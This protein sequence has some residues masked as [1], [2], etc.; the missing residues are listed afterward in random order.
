ME[1]YGTY[2]GIVESSSDP[3]KLGRCKV[4]VP[5]FHGPGPGKYSTIDSSDL[6]WAWPAGMPMGRN[7]T[8]GS[9]SW[10]PNPGDQVFVRFLDG[11]PENPIWEWGPRSVKASEDYTV[12]T[13]NGEKRS[14]LDYDENGRAVSRATLT[15]YDHSLIFTPALTQLRSASGSFLELNADKDF[16]LLSTSTGYSISIANSG[17]ALDG[18]VTLRTPLGSSIELDDSIQTILINST[19]LSIL[20]TDIS[21]HAIDYDA[22]IV[23]SS[24]TNV[25]KDLG[26]YAGGQVKFTASE[27][28][29]ITTAGNLALVGL[30]GIRLGS[31]GATNPVVRLSDLMMIVQWLITHTHGN[32]NNGSPTTPP[33]VP[34]PVPEGS[35]NVFCM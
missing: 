23:G 9:M 6:P 20:A 18:A 12:G 24:V 15:R 4:R 32:G 7:S 28:M 31:G 11:E 17:T 10:L 33:M 27:G 16:L 2:A 13:E 22:T 29:E 5:E 26:L 3:E 19:T 30:K 34:P 1:L 21:I 35:A 8:S 14:V 25:V